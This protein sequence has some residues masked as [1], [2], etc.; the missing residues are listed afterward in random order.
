MD[1]FPAC[2]LLGHSSFLAWLS[3]QGGL[4][5]NISAPV[6]P[7]I[8]LSLDRSGSPAHFGTNHRGW[9]QCLEHL[10]ILRAWEEPQT[11]PPKS[12]RGS[13]QNE[14]KKESAGRYLQQ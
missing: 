4:W 11:I 12:G 13:L 3:F 14:R 1:I 2:F 7:T 6:V 5:Q 8:V 10:C 9:W